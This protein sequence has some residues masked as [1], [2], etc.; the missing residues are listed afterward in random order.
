MSSRL[1][2]RINYPEYP[3]GPTYFNGH[4]VPTMDEM[5]A[6][7]SANVDQ[8][9]TTVKYGYYAAYFFAVTIFLAVVFNA[10][11]IWERR[12]RCVVII[13]LHLQQPADDRPPASRARPRTPSLC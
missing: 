5:M 7:Q 9:E 3:E 11:F 6:Y 1:R 10:Y 12:S 4:Y 8:W 2:A 13:L